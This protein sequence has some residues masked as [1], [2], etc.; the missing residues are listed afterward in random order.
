M[1]PL[2]D[3][4]VVFPLELANLGAF[5]DG[6]FAEGLLSLQTGSGGGGGGFL[7]LDLEKDLLLR[8]PLALV[9]CRV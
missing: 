7:A 6:E 8:K 1:S 4:M 5:L 3:E 2:L 9:V